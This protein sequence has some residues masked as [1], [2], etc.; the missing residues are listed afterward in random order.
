VNASKSTFIFLTL[1]LNS[2]FNKNKI[3]NNTQYFN[4]ENSN[5]HSF[6]IQDNITELKFTAPKYLD[7]TFKWIHSS[8]GIQYEKI[9]VQNKKQPIFLENG[10][11]YNNPKHFT[12]VTFKQQFL[13]EVQQRMTKQEV[14]ENHKRD[15][16][17]Y[18]DNR[19]AKLFFNID[20]IILANETYYSILG[21]YFKPQNKQEPNKQVIMTNFNAGKTY[22]KATFQ[23]T[24]STIINSKF[25]NDCIETIKSIQIINS[26]Y[27]QPDKTLY[28]NL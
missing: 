23:N 2:C 8:C 5:S 12:E 15:K 6:I 7:T 27:K 10:F 18:Y 21:Y 1:I 22:I 20:T 14:E 28:E 16:N 4:I 24:D 17:S 26:R 25:I 11:Y 13:H 9:R 19:E 3:E